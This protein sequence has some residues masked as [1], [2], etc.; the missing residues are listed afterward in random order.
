MCYFGFFFVWWGK[1]P[2]DSLQ[3]DIFHFGNKSIICTDSVMRVI[4]YTWVNHQIF[5]HIS[6]RLLQFLYNHNIP[7]ETHSHEMNKWK[8]NCF[9]DIELSMQRFPH[10]KCNKMVLRFFELL[11]GVLKMFLHNKCQCF[12]GFSTF[13]GFD[14]FPSDKLLSSILLYVITFRQYGK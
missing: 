6:K 12:L 10:V 14:F 9:P 11:S 4:L 1:I 3:I 2:H 8:T 7:Q 5:I 13:E